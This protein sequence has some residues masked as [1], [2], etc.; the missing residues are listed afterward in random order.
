MSASAR[1]TPLKLLP[2]IAAAA[3]TRAKQLNLPLSTYITVLLWNYVQAPSRDIRVEP[4]SPQL[5]RTHVPCTIRRSVWLL[6][7]PQI[8]ASQLS[9]NAFVEAVVAR[10]LRSAEASLA[11]LPERGSTKTRLK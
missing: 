4:D 7:K 6:V 1:K 3:R 8:S 9:A 5:A 2:T 11:I 10:D